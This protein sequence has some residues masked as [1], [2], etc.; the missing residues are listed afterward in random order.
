M[1]SGNDYACRDSSPC[2][3]INSPAETEKILTNILAYKKA[4]RSAD[5]VETQAVGLTSARS[6]TV[7]R[8]LGLAVSSSRNGL[9]LEEE[10]ASLP[11]SASSGAL[12]STATHLS[13]VRE[14]SSAAHTHAY[15]VPLPAFNVYTGLPE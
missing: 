2:I 13:P 5:F 10:F 9:L 7:R 11:P 6:P 15:H 3:W 8:G 4:D 14:V 1:Q 12:D